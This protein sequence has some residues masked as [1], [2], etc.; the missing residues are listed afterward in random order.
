MDNSD[1]ETGFIIERRKEGGSYQQAG[2]VG[3]NV[4][5][6]TDSDLTPDTAYTY[7]V[8]AYNSLGNSPY[9]SAVDTVTVFLNAPSNLLAETVS[10]SQV[11]LS[12]TDRSDNEGGFKIEPH[13]RRQLQADCHSR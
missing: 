10:R 2:T 4:T 12:W 8:R 3:P 9:R 1:N 13:L 7:R 5:T 11:K 6:Y